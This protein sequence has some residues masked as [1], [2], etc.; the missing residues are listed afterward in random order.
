MFFY[1]SRAGLCPK[2]V[3]QGVQGKFDT[4]CYGEK[5]ARQ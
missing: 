2:K 1:L 5:R 3:G 4:G